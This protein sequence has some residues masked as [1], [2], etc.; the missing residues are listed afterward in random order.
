[1]SADGIQAAR[2]LSMLPAEVR[3]R[4]V[5]AL[6][7][8]AVVLRGRVSQG[9]TSPQGNSRERDKPRRAPAGE[10]PGSC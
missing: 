7:S 6:R 4:I 2:L 10:C 9:F 5:T 3:D 8:L 1:M